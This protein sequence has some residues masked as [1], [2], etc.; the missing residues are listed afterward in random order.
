M[1]F[2]RARLARRRDRAAAGFADYDFLK[3]RVS[4]ALLER[5]DDTPRRFKTGL[6]LGAATGAA[7]AA[8][9]ASGKAEAMLTTDISPGMVAAARAA[10]LNAACADEEALGLGEGVFDLVVSGLS[11]HWVNDL[12]G[13]LIQIRRVLQPDGL[14][15]A[16]LPGAGTLAEL[17]AALTEAEV[18]L[19]GG[20][21]LRLSP[22]PSLSDMA[23]LM[24]RAG[25][26][27]PVVDRDTLNVRYAAPAKLLA[28]LKGMAERAAFAGG[29]GRVLP[30]RVLQ[31][32]FD[33]YHARFAD[34]DGRLRASFEIIYLSG[35]APGPDQP[36]PLARGSAKVSLADA[37]RAQTTSEPANPGDQIGG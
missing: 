27:L 20:A 25:F 23:N 5:I 37:V 33:I 12:P 35:W 14:F 6:E 21:S 3:A 18:E 32:A 34:A 28:D 22:L 4:S 11:L 1:I 30:R 9:L 31:R 24:Q 8:L 26:Q 19:T 13:A 10:G 15:I 2:D 16:A 7:S 36:R 29:H 17:R